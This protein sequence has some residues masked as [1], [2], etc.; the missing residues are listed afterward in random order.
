MD[1][2]A[3]LAVKADRDDLAGFGVVAEAGGIGHADELELDQRLRHLQRFRNHGA[4]R[5]DIGAVGDDEELAVDEAVGAA[6]IGR[7]R[8]R[9]REGVAHHV[10]HVH[11]V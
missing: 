7:P 5:V 4:Q 11:G 2:A 9:H 3:G 8:Q 1:I 10:G 6:R